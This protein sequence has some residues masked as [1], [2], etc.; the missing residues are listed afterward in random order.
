MWKIFSSF[1]ILVHSGL[2]AQV[3][4]DSM[5]V[6]WN[7]AG[8]QQF[9][10]DTTNIADV[11]LFGAVGNGSANDYPA[12]L[13]ALASL[14]GHSGIVYFPPGNYLLNSTIQL[15]DSVILKGASSS[16]TTLTFDFGG[17][18]GN[19]INVWAGQSHPY[20][21]LRSGYAKGSFRLVC[22][23]AIN[24]S[25]GDYAE[26]RE[27]NGS[28][29][30]NPVFW[31]DY[32]VG[33]MVKIDSVHGDTL[34][35][36]HALRI[37][38]DSLLNVEIRKVNMRGNTGIQCMR[39]LRVDSTAPSVNYGIYFNF[40][41]NCHVRGVEMEHTIGAMIWAEASTALEITGNYFHH[42]YE[43]TGSST[44]GYGVV[45]AVHTGESK[46]E[47]NIFR[48]L[49]HAMMVKQGANGNVYAY[50]YSIE[51]T[52]S[53]FPS[54]FGGDISLHGHYAYA[55]LF[56]GNICQNLMLDQAYGSSGPFN[57]FF[58]NRVERYGIILS[59]GTVNTNQNNFIGNDITG[60]GLGQGQYVITGTGHLLYG[61][62]DNGTLQPPGTGLLNDTSYY[63]TGTPSFWNI[64]EPFPNI[65]TPNPVTGQNNPAR[66]RFLSGG[67]FTICGEELPTRV[68]DIKPEDFEIFPN[69]ACSTL[70]I[71]PGRFAT[72]VDIQDATGKRMMQFISPAKIQADLDVSALPAGIYFI[73][74]HDQHN[75]PMT[76][77]FVKM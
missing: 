73:T 12:V 55:N 32:S 44:K 17:I 77:K 10:A 39:I 69:P 18:T 28:W 35:L 57:T 19:C 67:S 38:Y 21:A 2:T 62:N 59:S 36:E 30:T 13:S 68:K 6:E 58:R 14:S 22:D 49:R 53:E 26:L 76:K 48:H 37:D 16:Q 24:F 5:R 15:P 65:G 74:L 45:M 60:T 75:S 43:Y 63:L 34:F 20:Y 41:A 3:I 11:T 61:N 23:S 29:D 52:R 4:P 33:Q 51:P 7:Y 40:A 64:T 70:T 31:A 1:F 56:E 8:V 54:D 66:Q 72:V 46:I 9:Y 25:A 27:E 50:N 42:S 47:N 71:Y